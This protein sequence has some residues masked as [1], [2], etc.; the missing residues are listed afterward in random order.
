MDYCKDLSQKKCDAR[1]CEWRLPTN[2]ECKAPSPRQQAKG[3]LNICAYKDCY[4]K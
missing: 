3:V 1:Y 2:K 4:K